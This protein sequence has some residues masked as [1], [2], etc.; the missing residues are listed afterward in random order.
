MHASAS[1]LSNVAT[2]NSGEVQALEP[3]SEERL[4]AF[5]EKMRDELKVLQRAAI[6]N[7]MY[8]SDRLVVED[9]QQK[10]W[11]I[12]AGPEGAGNDHLPNA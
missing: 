12:R 6:T 1:K 2:K 3:L 5:Y 9:E 4:V 7:M 11:I 8:S 10:D